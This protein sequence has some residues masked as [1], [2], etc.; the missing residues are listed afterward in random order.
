[1]IEWS[2][3]TSSVGDDDDGGGGASS[4]VWLT[5]CSFNSPEM[6]EMAKLAIRACVLPRENAKCSHVIY[7]A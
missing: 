5:G 3:F 2:R 1:M 6:L 7:M 4:G